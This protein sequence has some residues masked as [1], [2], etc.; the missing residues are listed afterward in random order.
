MNAADEIA[1]DLATELRGRGITAYP[2][3]ELLS[4][5]FGL[6]ELIE[7]CRRDPQ[8]AYDLIA[9]RPYR[10][11]DPFGWRLENYRRRLIQVVPHELF[12]DDTLK[13]AFALVDKGKVDRKKLA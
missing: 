9:W 3:A 8:E 5:V 4:I 10:L 6:A 2:W 13:A 12:S 11:F 7:Q 1:Q